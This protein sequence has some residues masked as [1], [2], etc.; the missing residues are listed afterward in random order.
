MKILFQGDSITDGNRYKD[1]A[2]RWDLNHQIGHAYP[3]VVAATLGAKYPERRFQFK[4]RG[5]SGNQIA[6]L[7]GRW[8]GDTL[9]LKPDILSILI[10]VNDQSETGSDPQRFERVYRV[11]LDE[12]RQANP[13]VKFVLLEPFILPVKDWAAD[14]DARF[15]RMRRY[16]EAVARVA[17]D[18]GAVFVPL[19]ERFLELAE[20]Y[21]APYWLWDGVHPTEAG[22]GLIAFEWMRRVA[23]LLRLPAE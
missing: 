12:A 6:Q 8:K 14:W 5:V 19:Q 4:N 1:E 17:R 15:D 23:G 21:G 9:L 11:L 22:H 16:Q 20:A 3:Y 2:S 13:A 7:F 18:Y 10:G